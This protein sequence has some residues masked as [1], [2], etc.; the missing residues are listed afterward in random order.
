MLHFE[1]RLQRDLERLGIRSYATNGLL[2]K[3]TRNFV[4]IATTCVENNVFRGKV[5]S[6]FP[7][8][9]CHGTLFSQMTVGRWNIRRILYSLVN[10]LYLIFFYVIKGSYYDIKLHKKKKKK[11]TREKF[12]RTIEIYCFRVII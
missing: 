4:N 11:K 1:I 5:V 9:S 10:E 12:L 6:D 7:V 8:T 3:N 2:Y